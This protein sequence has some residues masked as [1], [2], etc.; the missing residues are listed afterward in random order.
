LR[1]LLGDLAGGERTQPCLFLFFIQK[2]LLFR[3]GLFRWAG[4]EA[5]L[6]SIER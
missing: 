3:G 4:G 2:L 6:V 1:L 5:R